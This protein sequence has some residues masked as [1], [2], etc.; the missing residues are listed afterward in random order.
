MPFIK[1]FKL[2]DP[3]AIREYSSTSM[4]GLC[5][6][7]INAGVCLFVCIFWPRRGSHQLPLRVGYMAGIGFLVGRP[8][9]KVRKMRKE[10]KMANGHLGMPCNGS[11][12]ARC[13]KRLF[14]RLLY[15]HELPAALLSNDQ[16][17]RPGSK[18]AEQKDE[19]EWGLE[20]VTFRFFVNKLSSLTSLPFLVF[21]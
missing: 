6:N 15:Y 11:P 10:G 9:S 19:T 12:L 4:P 7:H 8:S 20:L 21:L 13:W 14:H 2:A 18:E 3:F 1:A 5:C 17:Y 16:N